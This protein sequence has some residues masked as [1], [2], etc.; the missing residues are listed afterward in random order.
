MSATSFYVKAVTNGNKVAY[1]KIKVTITECG[2][3]V[4]TSNYP[5]YWNITVPF[6]SGLFKTHIFDRKFLATLFSSTVSYEKCP[7]TSF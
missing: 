3:E 4:L 5:Y 1:K 7:I 6:Q 2:S